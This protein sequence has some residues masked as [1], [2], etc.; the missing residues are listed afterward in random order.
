MMKSNQTVVLIILVLLSFAVINLYLS[1][2]N[3][4]HGNASEE[5]SNLPIIRRRAQP[6]EIYR[7]PTE[8]IWTYWNDVN[9]L[10]LTIHEIIMSW[11]VWNPTMNVVIIHSGNIDRFLPE[12]NFSM[13]SDIALRSDLIRLSLLYHYGGVWLDPS[14][15]LTN[16]LLPPPAQN[17]I[18]GIYTEHY[19]GSGERDFPES[20]F[21]RSR[22]HDYVIR[23]WRNTLYKAVLTN[24]FKLKGIS[25]TYV[26]NNES[27]SAYQ[28]IADVI[29]GAPVYWSE[30]LVVYVCYTYLYHSDPVFRQRIL[31]SSLMR[32]SEV[33]GYYLQFTFNWAISK[34][35][36]FLKSTT[37]S[38]VG[39]KADD[40]YDQFVTLSEGMIK[41]SAP[42]TGQLNLKKLSKTALLFN[43]LSF[44][45]TCS[46]GG[47][48]NSDRKAVGLWRSEFNLVISK[49]GGDISWSNIYN[50][51]RVIYDKKYNDDNI[52]YPSDIYL[53]VENIGTE[54]ASYLT[55]IID[56]YDSLPMYVGF[57][58]GDISTDHA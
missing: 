13:V 5:I 39:G 12:N 57:S 28:L 24:N 16:S 7:G 22:S 30:Y 1:S 36:G 21:I 52:Y 40:I 8:T 6:T 54:I 35:V 25:S 3:A 55:Y 17:N 41:L 2:C 33:K 50:G 45:S 20:W 9:S 32:P 19:S 31:A 10:T 53:Q 37:T 48:L 49:Y 46:G 11:K 42:H 18:E 29:G 58:Q 51:L 38:M 14:V 34:C 27:T 44:T 56:N 23:Q 47:G 26:Y 15:I 4:D 43:F